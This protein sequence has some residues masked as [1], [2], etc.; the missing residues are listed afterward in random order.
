MC[1]LDISPRNLLLD[2]LGRLCLLDWAYAGGYPRYFDQAVL[3][4]SGDP[5]FTQGLLELMGDEYLDEV[6]NLL[7]IS[8]G[9]TTAAL[10]RPSGLPMVTCPIH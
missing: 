3:T 9:L 4:R 8:F 2:E 6:R 7:A 1:H 10:T 5:D